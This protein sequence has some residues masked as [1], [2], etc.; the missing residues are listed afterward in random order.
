MGFSIKPELC[1]GKDGRLI[2]NMAAY[3]MQKSLNWGLAAA[4]GLF[5]LAGIIM[6]YWI[7]DKIVGIDNMKLG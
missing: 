6:L 3:H 4:I 5:L 7:Y 2:C 1:G